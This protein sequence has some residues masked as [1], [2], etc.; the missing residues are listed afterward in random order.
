MNKKIL[1]SILSGILALPAL[2]FA[3]VTVSGIVHGAVTTT[4]YIADGVIVIL[5]VVTGILFLSAQG[6]PE[7]L[8][9]ARAALITAV[10]GTVL[11]IIA[12][13]AVYLVGSAFNLPIT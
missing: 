9:S 10:V 4:F 11:V 5:W 2:A 12:N 6:A 7:K 1:F 3:Q 13:S 8:K